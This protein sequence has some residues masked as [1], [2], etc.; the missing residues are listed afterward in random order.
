MILQSLRTRCFK[1]SKPDKGGN[2]KPTPSSPLHLD[3]LKCSSLFKH[4]IDG[5]ISLIAV[6]LATIDLRDSKVPILSGSLS[7]FEQSLRTSDSRDLDLQMLLGRLL[8]IEQSPRCNDFKL[9]RS[10]NDGGNSSIRVPNKCKVSILFGTSGIILSLEHHK[11]CNSFRD[12]Q[13]LKSGI[14]SRLSQ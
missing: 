3:N 10:S 8:S 14:L 2:I 13:P 4:E 11:P 7:I 5:G 1:L 12:F 9:W 6:P